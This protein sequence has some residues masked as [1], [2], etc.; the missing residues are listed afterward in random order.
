[1]A[2]FDNVLHW[3]L[4]S[5][6]QVDEQLARSVQV[7]NSSRPVE[8]VGMEAVE[9]ETGTISSLVADASIEPAGESS[10]VYVHPNEF[11]EVAREVAPDS[12]TFLNSSEEVDNVDPNMPPWSGTFIIAGVRLSTDELEKLSGDLPPP[13]S[14]VVG[15]V[16]QIIAIVEVRPSAWVRHN[17]PPTSRPL[18]TIQDHQEQCQ[19]LVDRLLRLILVVVAALRQQSG[20]DVPADLKLK[21]DRLK[22]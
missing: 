14:T 20:G 5:L 18:Q 12:N 19:L 1:M 21:T 7:C 3:V 9:G 6:S 8:Q 15:L 10:Q 4:T 13:T 11:A 2:F 17:C 16:H 22:E